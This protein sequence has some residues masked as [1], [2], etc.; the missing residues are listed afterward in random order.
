MATGLLAKYNFAVLL[1]SLAVA[2]ASIAEWRRALFRRQLLLSAAIVVAAVLPHAMWALDHQDVTTARLKRLEEQQRFGSAVASV[3]GLDG[4]LSLTWAAM[5]ATLPMMLARAAA[6]RRERP[7]GS[8]VDPTAVL[9]FRTVVIVLVGSAVAVIAAGVHNVP[10]RYLTV[11][12]IPFPVWLALKY[13]LGA[14]PRAAL[15]Y[16]RA[17]GVVAI[18][19]AVALPARTL[20]GATQYSF[21]Y[22]AVARDIME[23]AQPPFAI[24]S[25][26]S[27]QPANLAIRIPG[28][29]PFAT[30]KNPER[31]LAI[32]D[33]AESE[34]SAYIE[35]K[36]AKHYEPESASR[37]I[38]HPYAYFSGKQ[39]RIYA[40]VWRR[41]SAEAP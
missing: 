21:P 40:Q 24:F 38:E 26:R 35:R 19:C 9:C 41:K 7:Q 11:L 32:W 1:A 6:Q 29:T 3:R 34:R 5:Y 20:F 12:L 37:L 14:T 31:I 25:A 15:L 27:E 2:A 23:F 17:A 10:E 8:L 28:A 18:G 16:A 4:L 36:L 22:A 33:A 13:R 30:T 39:L